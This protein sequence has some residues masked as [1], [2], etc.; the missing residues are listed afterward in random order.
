MLRRRAADP[1]TAESIVNQAA[2][3]F[4]GLR[5]R[6]LVCDG[7][8]TDGTVEAVREVCRDRAEN[9]PAREGHVPRARDGLGRATGDVVAPYAGDVHA[10]GPDVVADVF[11]ETVASG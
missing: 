8:S 1:R 11:E 10:H 9:L 2:L 5:L 6:V 4:G 7:A 3:R